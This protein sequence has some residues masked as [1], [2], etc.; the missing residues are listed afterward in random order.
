[1]AGLRFINFR[2]IFPNPKKFPTLF[3]AATQFPFNITCKLPSLELVAAQKIF[4]RFLWQLIVSFQ[5]P[6]QL[7][8]S[9]AIS[10]KNLYLALNP[11]RI[12][13]GKKRKKNHLPI[14]IIGATQTLA[15]VHIWLSKR[16]SVQKSS[17]P[18]RTHSHMLTLSHNS[19]SPLQH[20]IPVHSK[21]RS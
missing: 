10:Y 3:I 8:S 13:A 16:E 4:P 6:T 19:F 18:I 1:M 2:L 20:N 5:Y 21:N 11:P 7:S 15:V 14:C 17:P 9:S 12:W